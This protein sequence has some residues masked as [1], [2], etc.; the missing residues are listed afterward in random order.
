MSPSIS[1][2]FSLRV[3]IRVGRKKR[4]KT[5]NIHLYIY[6]AC[7]LQD[8]AWDERVFEEAVRR[9]VADVIQCQLDQ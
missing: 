1:I 2:T 7:T 8:S 6:Y 5:V 9:A 4:L 3:G